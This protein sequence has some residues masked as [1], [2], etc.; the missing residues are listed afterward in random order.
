M[1][2]EIVLDKVSEMVEQSLKQ[3]PDRELGY[4]RSA[5][6]RAYR[7]AVTDIMLTGLDHDNQDKA[8]RYMLELLTGQGAPFILPAGRISTESGRA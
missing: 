2:E 8:M 5:K 6:E 4:F 7:R 3:A 1:D